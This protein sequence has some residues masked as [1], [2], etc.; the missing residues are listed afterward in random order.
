M[1]NGLEL[2]SHPGTGRTILVPRQTV[3]SIAG[4]YPDQFNSLELLVACC[5]WGFGR[6]P[7]GRA[8]T[9]AM[10]RSPDASMIVD[11]IIRTSRANAVAGFVSLFENW[12]P[13]ITG[14]G[15]SFGTKLVHFAA[16]RWVDPVPL[17]YDRFVALAL[18]DAEDPS[19]PLPTDRVRSSDYE[20]YLA[21]AGKAAIRHGLEPE[22]V[23]YALFLHGKTLVASQS[24]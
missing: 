6:H 9:H 12:K 15:V 5:V 7:R 21:V 14:L 2:S 1:L 19:F 22:D 18:R 24:A 8:R 10:V 17:I 11:D 13:R 20:R 3:R 23:E 4:L 16:G